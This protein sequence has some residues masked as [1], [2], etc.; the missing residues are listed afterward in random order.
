MFFSRVCE[1]VR[2]CSR[3]YVCTRLEHLSRHGSLITL[4]SSRFH[5]GV[6][7]VGCMCC[8]PTSSLTHD[9][10]TSTSRALSCNIGFRFLTRDRR[11]F[12]VLYV[13]L[14][15]LLVSSAPTNN[16]VSIL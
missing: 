4:F 8:Q 16:M 10:V 13:Q 15:P 2:L 3:L 5:R 7:R 6:S 12:A 11:C 1:T 9:C 14:S